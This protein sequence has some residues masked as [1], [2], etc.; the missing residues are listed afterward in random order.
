[1]TIELVDGKAGVAH[2]SSGDKAII[3]QAK[4]SKSD[5]VFD[6]G[7]AFKC[8][9]GSAN[10]ATI[11]TGCASIQGLDWHIT[12]A[13][14]V[15]ISNGS[16]GMKRNDIICA[17]YHRDS[18]TGVEKV[19]LTV[20][21]GTPNATAAADPTIPS[22]KILSGAVDAYM[23]LWRIPLDGITVGT[24]VRLFTPRG[25]LWDSVTQTCQ[26]KFQDTS[27]FV[28]FAYGASNTITVK[29]GL[30]FMDLSSFQSTVTVG[31][32]T[33]WLFEAGVKPSKKISLGCVANVNGAAY[34]KQANWNTDGSVTII[35]GVG[36]SNLVQCFPRI[37]SVPDGVEFA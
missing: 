36:S 26:L 19:D 20:L 9:M 1:M 24:P 7:D 18:S 14:S 21:K 34:G 10:R 17:H 22:G 23:P 2:I 13:E 37:I 4:F 16:Q 8:T 30:I 28:P 27:S 35:G 15:T 3:H 33:V 5:V 29:D 32:F 6:W 25:A 12:S 11:G 31:N